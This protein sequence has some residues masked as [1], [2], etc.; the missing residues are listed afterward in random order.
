LSEV[1]TSSSQRAPLAVIG[2]SNNSGTPK[3]CRR[4]QTLTQDSGGRKTTPAMAAG[5]TNRVWTA[6]GIA[7][8]LD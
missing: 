5:V 6:P 1:I 8:L 2:W 3:M 4:T 7:A